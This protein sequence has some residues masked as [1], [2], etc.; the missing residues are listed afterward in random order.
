MSGPLNASA[1]NA[2]EG[3]L[4]QQQPDTEQN[5]RHDGEQHQPVARK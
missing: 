3:R 5:D 2:A 4:L 1:H